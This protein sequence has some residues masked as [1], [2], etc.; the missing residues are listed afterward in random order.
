[1]ENNTP[2]NEYTLTPEAANPDQNIAILGCSMQSWT[3]H[4]AIT[5]LKTII[6][7]KRKCQV[8]YLNADCLNIAFTNRAYRAIIRTSHRVFPDGS[9][10]KMASRLT[11][12]VMTDNLN[13]TDMFAPICEMAQ[14]N[15]YRIF[16]LGAKPG[17]AE[18][19]K[20]KLLIRYPQLQIAGTQHGYYDEDE[21]VI[22]ERINAS[23]PHILFVAMGVPQ[24]EGWISRNFDRLD[25]ALMMGV[26]GLFDYNADRIPRA[27]KFIRQLGIEWAW[28][29]LQEPQRMW[30][31]YILG[32]P[33]FLYR[34]LKHG[35]SFPGQ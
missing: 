3:M 5:D 16:F 1:M 21:A 27:P 29:L 23:K 13:G 17:V 33:L 22:V 24:Q 18:D 20:E 10:V 11:G 19:M 31:R 14:D 28:R 34:V 32:N 12:Q 2:A 30:K 25:C 26:G 6:T 4:D 35:K 9:G 8:S 7:N 15:G